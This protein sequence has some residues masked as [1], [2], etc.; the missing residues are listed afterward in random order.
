MYAMSDSNVLRQ[1]E[2]LSL[3]GNTDKQIHTR[4]QHIYNNGTFLTYTLYIT[5]FSNY[6][7]YYRSVAM[8]KGAVIWWNYIVY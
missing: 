4:I 3:N 7:S 5:H 8:N 6:I 2:N 1:N